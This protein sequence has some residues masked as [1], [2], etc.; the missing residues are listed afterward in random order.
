MYVHVCMLSAHQDQDKV[1]VDRSIRLSSFKRAI[2][3][4]SSDSG[5][6]DLINERLRRTSEQTVASERMMA[7]NEGLKAKIAG[8]EEQISQLQEQCDSQVTRCTKEIST[9][10]EKER[11]LISENKKLQCKLTEA[12]GVA[13]QL[14]NY[15]TEVGLSQLCKVV[16]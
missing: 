14:D 16:R 15:G 6:T 10:E 12:E 13:A 3:V 2:S 5:T 4:A 9:A 8:L 1:L 7:E 11:K